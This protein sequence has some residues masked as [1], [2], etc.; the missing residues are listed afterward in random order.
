MEE[1]LRKDLAG[2]CTVA[3]QKEVEDW[4]GSFEEHPP[5]FDDEKCGEALQLMER[6]RAAMSDPV[7]KGH[8]KI[9]L[10]LRSAAV[11]ILLV[12]GACLLFYQQAIRKKEK[13]TVP[14][15]QQ[16][17]RDKG[18]G[19][20]KAILTLGDGKT[21]VLD[22]AAGGELALQGNTRIMKLPGAGLVYDSRQ[23]PA[24]AADQPVTYNTLSTPRAAQY[25]LVLPDG[26]KVW[27]NT[28]S[29]IHY[30][31]AFNGRERK[32]EISG[33]AYF[34]IAKDPSR[35]FRVLITAPGKAGPKGADWG[36]EI[37]VLGTHF[38]VNAYT[39]EHA[40]NT[41][42]LEGSVKV[43][44]GGRQVIIKP[45]EQAQLSTAGA[46]TVQQANLEET[47]AWKSGLFQFDQAA[48]I[49]TVMRQ[50]ARW[51]DVEV[52]YTRDV[53]SDRFQGKMYRDENLSQV[54]KILEFSGVHFRLE[55][56]KIIVQ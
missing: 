48:T 41:T 56:K 33:E 23:N 15:A 42:L 8:G 1:L 32:V 39:D 21:I 22:S 37:E 34:E 31:T 17:Q 28:A 44:K 13:N 30:P 12:S 49:E 11:F 19:R 51:Y 3:E 20:S 9:V 52:V 14:L 45:G 27:L 55:G 40:I 47:M 29:S 5:L 16:E 43:N 10:L 24:E 38:N 18:P 4:Y 6:M 50:V 25:Q 7:S 36:G 2:D 46:I 53:A 26:S 54:L 35:P